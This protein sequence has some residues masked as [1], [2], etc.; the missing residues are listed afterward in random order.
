MSLLSDTPA[1]RRFVGTTL[2]LC[3]LAGIV[4]LVWCLYVDDVVNYDAVEYI[5]AAEKLA[6]RDWTGAFAVHQWPFFSFLMWLVGGAFGLSFEHAGELLNTVFFTA[7]SMLF[8]LVVRAFGGISRRLT[9]FAAMVAILHP[10]F[11]EYRAFIIRISG[12]IFKDSGE[13]LLL[14][15]KS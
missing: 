3:A 10:A 1:D 4:T 6:S 9:V 14:S 8:V 7:S 12:L 5:R 11:N 13:N 15:P 2:L